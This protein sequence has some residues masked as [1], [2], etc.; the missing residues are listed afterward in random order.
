MSDKDNTEYRQAL[1]AKRRE[2]L[3][4]VNAIASDSQ[5]PASADSEE[6]A[7]ERENE[8][9]LS[10]LDDEARQVVMQIDIALQRIKDGEYGVC[11]R[12]GTAIAPARLKAIPYTA[13][14]ID[15]A[16]QQDTG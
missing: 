11:R 2:L 15:C 16:D 7:M 6:Q 9:V 13:L 8:E 14:C 10:A 4:R 5:L 1:L 12:C 3:E